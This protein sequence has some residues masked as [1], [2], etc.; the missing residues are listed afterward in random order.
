MKLFTLEIS[1]SH[2]RVYG[3]SKL[4]TCH[5]CAAYTKQIADDAFIIDPKQPVFHAKGGFK[6]ATH[7]LNLAKESGVKLPFA[8]IT[9][10][11]LKEIQERGD[12]YQIDLSSVALL[13]RED[14][15]IPDERNL[16]KPKKEA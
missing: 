13:V 1:D 10:G 12:P 9:H 7:I 5:T 2:L 14:A 15:G 8:E 6:D 3:F 16:L 4:I 11:R